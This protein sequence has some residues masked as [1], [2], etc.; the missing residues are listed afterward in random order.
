MALEKLHF[1]G[2]ASGL[3]SDAIKYLN[4]NPSVKANYIELS[5]PNQYSVFGINYDA[6]KKAHAY[7]YQSKKL[8][9]VHNSP[10]I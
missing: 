8:P 5:I 3:R 4:K 9:Q 10:F 2:Y 6:L 1:G 7:F